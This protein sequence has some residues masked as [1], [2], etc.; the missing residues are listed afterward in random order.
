MG[1]LQQIRRISPYV[2]GIF[3]VLLVAFFTIGDPTVIDGLRGAV[4]SPTSQV[5]GSVNGEDIT[6]LDYENRVKQ[7]EENQRQQMAQ[8]GQMQ[9]ID[10]TALRQRVWDMMVEELLLK[11]QLKKLNIL[12]SDNTIKEQLIDNP[13]DFLRQSFTDSTGVFQKKQY[14]DIITNPNSILTRMGNASAEEKQQALANLRRDLINIEKMIKD[15]VQ[16][17]EVQ[18]AVS[19]SYSIISPE[20][21]KMQYINENTTTTAQVIAITVNDLPQE[22][23]AIPADEIKKYYENNKQ[24]FKQKPSRKI[25]YITI[26]LVASKEDSSKAYKRV[27][28]IQNALNLGLTEQE[29]DSI[30]ELKLSEFSGVTSDYK[31]ISDIDPQISAVIKDLPSK[32]VIGPI[33]K[34]DGIS[35]YRVD[36]KRT[37][38]NEV[39]KASHILISLNNNKDSAKAEAMKIYN[40]VKS[41]KLPFEVFATKYSQD[42]GSARNGGDLGYFGKGMMV[43]PFE[44]AAFGSAI[45]TIT[46]PVESQFGY[47]IIKVVDKKSEEIKYSEIKINPGI[48]SATRNQIFRDA[49][50]IEQQAKSGQKL[51]DIASKLKVNFAETPQF[52]ENSPVLGSRYLTSLAFANEVGTVLE[53]L[54]LNRL[55]VVIAQVSDAKEA[56]IATLEDAQ[57]DISQRIGKIIRLNKIKDKITEIYNK[58]KSFPTLEDAVKTDTSLFKYFRKLTDHKYADDIIGIGKEIALGPVLQKLKVNQISEPIRGDNSYI[59]VQVNERKAPDQN[60]VNTNLQSYVQNLH[61]QSKSNSF[62]QWFNAIKQ[63]AKIIDNRSNFYKDF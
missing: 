13:P 60:T 39:V 15:N 23:M 58:V 36:D 20:F 18:S 3:A 52:Q 11:Q 63:D 14:L 41:S 22:D 2:F 12:I 46:Q 17:R 29:K 47:H 43:K 9:E 38:T 24:Y 49:K 31:L 1:T 44:D 51:E 57:V 45:G 50:S 42:Q 35:F 40:E 30:F 21:A 28:N 37:G 8:Q 48:S 55:G 32:S 56:G 5:L 54:E 34:V 16:N 27:E 59:I 53:P 62:Y 10:A 25:K 26:P 6:Y 4:G 7:E 61:S 19:T 33:E